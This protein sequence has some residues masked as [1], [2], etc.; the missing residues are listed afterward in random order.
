M[1]LNRDDVRR[2]AFLARIKI[3]DS[4]LKPLSDELNGIIGWVEQL[5]EVNTDG[6]QPMTSVTE[7]LA[8]QRTDQVTEE[9]ATEKVLANAPDRAQNFYAVPKVVD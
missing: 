1:S 6:V 7:M 3:E 2:I 8:P 5:S 4:D 9:E